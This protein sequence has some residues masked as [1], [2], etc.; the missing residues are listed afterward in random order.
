LTNA[1]KSPIGPNENIA[2]FLARKTS[3][4]NLTWKLFLRYYKNFIFR[5][6]ESI[7]NRFFWFRCPKENETRIKK[8]PRIMRTGSFKVI[9]ACHHCGAHRR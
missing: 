8:L 1:A 2:A 6:A 4:F 3:V 9:F 5:M 7:E